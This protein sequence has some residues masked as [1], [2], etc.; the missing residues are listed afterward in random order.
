MRS[1]GAFETRNDDSQHLLNWSAHLLGH[2]LR[3]AAVLAFA[4]VLANA[5]RHVRVH[6]SWQVPDHLRATLACELSKRDDTR[7]S[8]P[9]SAS[10]ITL[11]G[12]PAD[13][14]LDLGTIP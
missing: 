2:L 9:H 3:S 10:A 8:A 12:Q 6:M 7:D 14:P 5:L 13:V 11:A 4:P 1:S